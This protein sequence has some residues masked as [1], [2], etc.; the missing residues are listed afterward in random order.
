MAGSPW[1]SPSSRYPLVSVFK[2]IL[3]LL[4]KLIVP[5]LTQ[6]PE[7]GGEGE[8]GGEFWTVR[9]NPGED[10]LSSSPSG[11]AESGTY[12]DVPPQLPILFPQIP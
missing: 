2:L 5:R 11:A 7:E 4:S 3:P 9:M 6:E 10:N 1:F 8:E 12:D